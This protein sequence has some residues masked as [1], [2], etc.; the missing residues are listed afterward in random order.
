MEV[1]IENLWG[2]GRSLNVLQMGLR[3]IAVFV[4]ALVLFR[5]S[6][7]RSFGIGSPLDNIIII[8]LGA[9]LSRAVV[10]ASPFIPVVTTCTLIVLLH[11]F[12]SWLKVRSSRFS[13]FVEGE[14]IILFKDDQFILSNMNRVQ[15]NKED[16]MQEV[17]KAALTDDLSKVK[18]IF[19]ERSGHIGI[20]KNDN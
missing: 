4:I 11:R 18:E 5:I 7:R 8:L 10:G 16:V 15:L 14:K 19:I 6:G 13:K 9:V 17:R 12:V 1:L 2:S 3:G 20:V